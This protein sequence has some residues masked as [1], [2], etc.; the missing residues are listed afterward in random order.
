MRGAAAM[1]LD[2][3]RENKTE[4]ILNNS[5]ESNFILMKHDVNDQEGKQLC[6]QIL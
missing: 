2:N 6:D 4:K 5:V 1:L 3:F